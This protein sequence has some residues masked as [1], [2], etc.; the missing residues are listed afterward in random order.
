MVQLGRRVPHFRIPDTEVALI[1]DRETVGEDGPHPPFF[2][3][4]V[5]PRRADH[6]VER[7]HGLFGP[8]RDV[9]G[10]H[11]SGLQ[12]GLFLD[13]G[14]S[15]FFAL[16]EGDQDGIHD[17]LFSHLVPNQSVAVPP[18][19]WDQSHQR[20]GDEGGGVLLDLSMIPGQLCQ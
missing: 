19:L 5:S 8:T 10:R 14:A 18:E 2:G 12:G 16:G 17:S 7:R 20:A 15:R 4:L 3:P 9:L 13:K 1:S 11:E 6:H